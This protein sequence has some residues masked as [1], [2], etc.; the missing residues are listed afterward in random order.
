[1][2]YSRP[3]EEII[4]TRFSCRLYDPT[5]LDPAL[6]A[7]ITSIAAQMDAGPLGNTP[8]FSL[9]AAL[10]D[11]PQAL[12]GL[13]TYGMIQGASAYLIGAVK[14]ADHFLEDFGYQLELLALK[15]TDLGLGTCWLGGTLTRSTFAERIQTHADEVVPC[16]LATG[17]IGNEWLARRNIVRVM[18]GSRRQSWDELFFDGEYGRPLTQQAAGP[19]ARPLEMVRLAPSASN[20]QPWRIIKDGARFHFY[21][22]RTAGKYDPIK[23]AKSGMQDNQRVDMGIAMCHLELSARAAGLTGQW[24]VSPVETPA[25]EYTITWVSE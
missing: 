21:L 20:K 18:G 13:G 24:T 11:D 10:P 17:R 9:A 15:L 8:R 25:G 5:P 19:Y 16:V 2:D 22:R 7:E 23:A 6:A 4:K 12:K 1:M 14:P 3:I